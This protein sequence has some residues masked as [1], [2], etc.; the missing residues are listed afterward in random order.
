[1][2]WS[3]SRHAEPDRKLDLLDR[4]L[5]RLRGA[6]RRGE[7]SAR[8]TSAAEQMRLAALAV[9][10][11]KRALIAEYP[12][13]DSGGRQLLNLGREE[14]RWLTLTA[15]AIVEEY[16]TE[17]EPIAAPHPARGEPPPRG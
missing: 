15:D 6:V 4:R 11:A 5:G 10:K 2:G 1:M 9:I 8:I 14:E 3:V 13:R 7:S 17:A 16:G 12:N